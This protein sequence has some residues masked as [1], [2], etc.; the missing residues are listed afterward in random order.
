[1]TSSGIEPVTFRL[2]AKCLNQQRYRAHPSLES[3]NP[4]LL[5]VSLLTHLVVLSNVKIS[6]H[7]D[8]F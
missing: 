3:P 2:V 4:K 8:C 6:F 7:D 1:M 5:T